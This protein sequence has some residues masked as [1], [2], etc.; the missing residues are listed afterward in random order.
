MYYFAQLSYVFVQNVTKISIL[1]GFLRIFPQ[2]WFRLTIYFS[3]AWVTIRCI[4]YYCLL[5]LRCLPLQATWDHS[6]HGKC[7]SLNRIA[8]IGA[9]F[10][11]AEDIWI[12][13]LPI[14]LLNSLKVARGRKLALM[15]MFS[16]GVL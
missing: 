10:S 4:I 3:L 12:L 14:P 9:A 1:L 13:V 15:A 5:G 11:I 8:Y 7:L 6:I 2:R 16:V